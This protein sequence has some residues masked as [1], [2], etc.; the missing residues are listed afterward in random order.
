MVDGLKFQR[1]DDLQDPD[2][3]FDVVA[4]VRGTDIGIKTEKASSTN[5]S[6]SRLTSA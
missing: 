5:N 3:G 4:G 2:S 6:P 1:Q